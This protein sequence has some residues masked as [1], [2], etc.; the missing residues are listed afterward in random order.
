MYHMVRGCILQVLPAL[1]SGGVERGTL[2]LARALVAAGYGSMV[3]SAGG[4]LVAR[5]EAEGSTHLT[6]DVGRKSLL[7]LRHIW[8]IRQLLGSGEIDV[9]HVRS[10]LPAWIIWL[11]WSSLPAARR[12]P[13]VSTVHGPYSVNVYSAVMTRGERVIAVSETI[14]DYIRRNYRVPEDRIRLIYRGID[15]E[16]FPFGHRPSDDWLTVWLRDFPQ[17][18]GKRVLALPARVTRWKGQADFL[19]VMAA[20]VAA[21]ERVHGL[22]VGDVQKGREDFARELRERVQALGMESHISFTGHRSDLRDVMAA[23][24]IVFSL[25][26]DP[27]AFGRVPVEALSLGR[28]VIGYDHGGVGESLRAIYPAGLVPVGDIDAVV[29]RTCEFL[30]AAPPVPPNQPFTLQRMTDA[31]LAV[32]RELVELPRQTD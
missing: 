3:M 13:L 9:V 7:T 16:E 19:K 24:D 21:G 32:Y 15:P 18:P 1:N 12:P 20:L 5:L 25:A 23:S 17:L 6:I 14:R 4:R 10:R 26:R 2:D 8:A 31:T 28:P 22:I 11:T 30:R 29:A 27:E